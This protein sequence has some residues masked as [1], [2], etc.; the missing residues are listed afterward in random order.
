VFFP[1]P[2]IPT[3]PDIRNRFPWIDQHLPQ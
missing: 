2:R 1:G 3:M